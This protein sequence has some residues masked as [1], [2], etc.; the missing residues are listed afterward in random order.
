MRAIFIN[1]PASGQTVMFQTDRTMI[2][3]NAKRFLEAFMTGD[4][5]VTYR[6]IAVDTGGNSIFAV[7]KEL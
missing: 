3:C 2:E 4:T 5:K 1:G 7:C 6:K